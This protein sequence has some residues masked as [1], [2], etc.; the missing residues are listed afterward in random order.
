MRT[1]EDLSPEERAEIER[2]INEGEGG[3]SEASEEVAMEQVVAA[4]KML[5]EQHALLDEKVEMLEKLVQEEIIGGIT[6]LYHNNQR[7]LRVDGLRQGL[8]EY[9]GI[10]EAF[11]KAFPKKDGSP[12]DI[13]EAIDEMLEGERGK[14]GYDEMAMGKS[15]AEKIKGKLAEIAAAMGPGSSME[16]R[17][18]VEPEDEQ[19]RMLKDV[20]NI[21]ARQKGRR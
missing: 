1:L 8:G 17:V 19:A 10:G 16:A 9:A 14:E 20:E 13:Y 6:K 2:I 21:V 7:A 11:G 5:A 3:H 15:M 12:R 18:E 4:I